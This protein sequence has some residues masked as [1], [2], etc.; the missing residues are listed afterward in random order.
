MTYM[1]TKQFNIDQM[2]L[3]NDVLFNE[4][5]RIELIISETKHKGMLKWFRKKLKGINELRNYIVQNNT[6]A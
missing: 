5:D 6:N 1:I 4:M 2:L 3:L